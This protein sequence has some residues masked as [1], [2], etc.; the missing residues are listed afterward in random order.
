[1]EFFLWVLIVIMWIFPFSIGKLITDILGFLLIQ[2][3]LFVQ[4]LIKKKCSHNWQTHYFDF[5]GSETFCT[6]CNKI[7]HQIMILIHRIHKGERYCI[8]RIDHNGKCEWYWNC[9]DGDFDN[10]D[11]IYSQGC[12]TS[13]ADAERYLRNEWNEQIKFKNELAQKI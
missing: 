2:P 1:M 13:R 4:F 10:Y 8:G 9:F 12:A 6:K 7:K 11:T 5:S 3:I